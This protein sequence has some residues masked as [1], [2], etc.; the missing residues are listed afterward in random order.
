MQLKLLLT[1][2]LPQ[3]VVQELFF[4]DKRIE[5][6]EKLLLQEL[7]QM[8]KELLL[9]M[10]KLDSPQQ[11]LQELGQKLVLRLNKLELMLV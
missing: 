5:R 6:K 3:K 2:W 11:M 8:I 7:P 4:K 9:P 1:F 10:H